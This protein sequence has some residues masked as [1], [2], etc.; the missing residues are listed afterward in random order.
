MTTSFMSTS[1]EDEEAVLFNRYIQNPHI[2]QDS[3]LV[4]SAIDKFMATVPK[5]FEVYK[6]EFYM[7]KTEE[8]LLKEEK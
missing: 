1:Y 3:R 8:L 5:G 2:S 7:N 4:A 6:I